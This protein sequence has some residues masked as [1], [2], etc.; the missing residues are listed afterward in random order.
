MVTQQLRSTIV[1]LVAF[2]LLCSFRRPMLAVSIIVS[3]LPEQHR[4]IY[5]DRDQRFFVASPQLSDQRPPIQAAPAIPMR[6]QPYHTVTLSGYDINPKSKMDRRLAALDILRP[7]AARPTWEEEGEGLV[8][9]PTLEPVPTRSSVLPFLV[10][11]QQGRFVLTVWGDI[12]EVPRCW[13]QGCT[14]VV[15]ATLSMSKEGPYYA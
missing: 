3:R 12:Y 1:S 5:G 6:V 10:A 14:Q 13:W 4:A 11:A 15:E 8:W 9:P 7:T 2:F